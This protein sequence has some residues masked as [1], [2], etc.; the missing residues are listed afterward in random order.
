MGEAK[1]NKLGG[2]QINK[3]KQNAWLT[4]RSGISYYTMSALSHFRC[5]E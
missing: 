3:L 2:K 5:D 1:I 4:N